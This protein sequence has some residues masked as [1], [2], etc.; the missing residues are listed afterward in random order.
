MEKTSLGALYAAFFRCSAVTFGGGY[1]MLPILEKE[2]TE[3]HHWCEKEELLDYYAVSQS[4]PGLI[5]VNTS[6]FVGYKLR[7]VPGAIVS[8]LGVSS[9]CLLIIM[10]IAAFLKNF[11]ENV[12]VQYALHGISVCVCALILSSLIGLWKKGVKDTPA[13]VIF[14]AALALSLFTNVS[15]VITVLLGAAAGLLLKRRKR[16]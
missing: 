10:L 16:Q 5:A 1:A 15:P 13:L 9:P 3:K 4:L 6:I 12:Y 7:K 8:A 14:L 11:R 2:M